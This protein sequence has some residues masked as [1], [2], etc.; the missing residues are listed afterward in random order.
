MHQCQ[1]FYG[2]PTDEQIENYQEE[3]TVL[4]H[5][6]YVKSYEFG[7]KTRDDRRVVSW[8]YTVGPAGDLEGSRSGGLYPSAEIADAVTFNFLSYSDPWFSLSGTEKVNI[9][10]KHSVRRSDGVPVLA[11]LAIRPQI[12]GYVVPNLLFL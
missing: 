5:G 10:A 9:K 1:R 7:F 12:D 11:T 4:L 6:G 8:Y 2:L 3:L